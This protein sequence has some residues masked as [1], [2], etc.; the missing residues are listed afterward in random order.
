M[1]EK[2]HLHLDNLEDVEDDMIWYKDEGGKEN[3][4]PFKI[5][6]VNEKDIKVNKHNKIPLKAI[7]YFEDNEIAPVGLLKKSF[8]T[9]LSII[10]GELKIKFRNEIWKEIFDKLDI[11]FEEQIIKLAM[12]KKK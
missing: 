1:K 8:E 7:L 3:G 11:G 5:Q 4:I 10:N 6:L 2:S 9:E 12:K